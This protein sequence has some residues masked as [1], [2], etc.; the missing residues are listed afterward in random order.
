VVRNK[1]VKPNFFI[2]GA[3]KAGTTALYT[4]LSEHPHVYMSMMKEPHFFATDFP[5]HRARCCSTLD[6]YLRLFADARP[7]CHQAVGEA[8]VH[9]IHS[10]EAV[11]NIY[12]FDPEAKLIAMLRHPAELIYAFHGQCVFNAIEDRADFGVAWRLQAARR[13]GVNLPLGCYEPAFVQ[14]EQ[15]GK[16]G[17]QVES[18]MNIFPS[19]QLLFILFE[20][21]VADAPAVYQRVLNFLEIPPDARQTFQKVNES[22]KPRFRWL[23]D[24]AYNRPPWMKRLYEY[25]GVRGY[26]IK[27]RLLRLNTKKKQRSSLPPAFRAELLGVFR[28]DILK[29]GS[30]LKRDLGHWLS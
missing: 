7:E 19:E 13:E 24:L 1:T 27:G 12:N 8:S 2:I 22:K 14:Y 21:F 15:I 4:Y 16:L 20:D 17:R 26:G 25:S 5:N 18:V 9:Y 6:D 3:P 30:L 23:N 28:Q 29:L 11:R 10:A